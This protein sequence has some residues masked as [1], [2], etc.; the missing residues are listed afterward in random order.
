MGHR[1]LILY[2]LFQ[3]LE[4]KNLLNLLHKAIII[5][6]PKPNNDIT[7]DLILHEY[8]HKNL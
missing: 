2:K 5:L 7:I 6:I 3:K 1:K 8:W 4:E